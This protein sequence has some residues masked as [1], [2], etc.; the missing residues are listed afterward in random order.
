MQADPDCRVVLKE[1]KQWPI[2]FV[3]GH[4]ED[5]VEVTNGLVTVNDHNQVHGLNVPFFLEVLTDDFENIQCVAYDETMLVAR[6]WLLV[7]G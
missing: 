3:M 7:T 5:V 6:C 2:T 1:V 4:F